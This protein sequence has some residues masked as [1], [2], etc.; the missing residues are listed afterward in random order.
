MLSHYRWPT[1]RLDLPNRPNCYNPDGSIIFRQR[2]HLKE[3]TVD[4]MKVYLDRI[5]RID[6]IGKASKR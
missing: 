2:N 5:Y 3:G 6:G 4:G 1:K